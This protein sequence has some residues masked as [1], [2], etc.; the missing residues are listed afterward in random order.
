MARRNIQCGISAVVWVLQDSCGDTEPR[1]ERRDGLGRSLGKT[2]KISAL[3]RFSTRREAHSV[4]WSAGAATEILQHSVQL[5]TMH[6]A[7]VTLL[8]L[9]P[10]E[11]IHV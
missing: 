10:A 5:G 8:S 2:A 7:G 3:V 6:G 9:V 1:Q 11:T 4:T